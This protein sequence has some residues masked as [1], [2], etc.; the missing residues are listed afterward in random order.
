MKNN[1]FSIYIEIIT[2]Y[3]SSPTDAGYMGIYVWELDLNHD[4]KDVK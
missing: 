4:I 1:F 3:F 2:N